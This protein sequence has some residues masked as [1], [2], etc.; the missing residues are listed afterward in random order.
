MFFALPSYASN[1]AN[2]IAK[3]NHSSCAWNAV[4]YLSAILNDVTFA[5]ENMKVNSFYLNI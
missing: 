4:R 1:A 2:T 3:L 5:G